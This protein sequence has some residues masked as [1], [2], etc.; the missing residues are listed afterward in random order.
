[1]RNNPLIAF[2]AVGF[3]FASAT[4]FTATTAAATIAA[5]DYPYCR[6]Q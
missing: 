2:S 4:S 1:M 5:A 6:M 3:N